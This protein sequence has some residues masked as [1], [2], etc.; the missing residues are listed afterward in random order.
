[1][2]RIAVC[3]ATRG[4]IFT[5]VED[6]LEKNLVGWPYQIFRTKDKVIPD[7]QNY[8]VEKALSDK[9]VTHILYSEEDN[10]MPETALVDMIELDADVACIDYGVAGYS[11]LTKDKKTGEILW[12]G[13]GCTLI[14]REVFEGLE[15]P[16]FRSDKAL[17]I[18]DWPEIRWVDAGRQ[19][20][21]LQDIYFFMKAREAGF[22]IKQA[23]G[24][25]KHLQLDQLG[26]REINNGLHQI[27]QKPVISK[28]QTL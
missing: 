2:I 19:A 20:Y 13:L 22:T 27:S 1:M 18:N 23:R 25:S 5:E 17:L 7:S 15:K 16:Y 11:C 3:L 28:Y 4:L 8:L 26:R 10:V 21:G 6:A 9:D 24:E 12:C 14:K